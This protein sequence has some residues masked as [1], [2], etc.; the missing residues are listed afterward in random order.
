MVLVVLV[1]VAC[2]LSWLL[3][4]VVVVAVGL[5][6]CLSLPLSLPSCCELLYCRS[7]PLPTGAFAPLDPLA[8]PPFFENDITKRIKRSA[9]WA[10]PRD[11]G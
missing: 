11:W 6:C 8:P 2:R 7:G 1:V 9:L 5:C 4:L 3:S 10:T